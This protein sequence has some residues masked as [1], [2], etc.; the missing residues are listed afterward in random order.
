MTRSQGLVSGRQVGQLIREH[1]IAAGWTQ[2][3]LAD[4]AGL[5]IGFLRDLEQGRTLWPRWGSVEALAGALGLGPGQRAGLISSTESAA[6]G[7]WPA[8]NGPIL[9]GGPAGSVQV[10]IL[11][12]LALTRA[13]RPVSLGPVRQRAVLAMLALE[14]NRRVRISDLIEVLWPGRQPPTAVT[15]VQGYISGLRRLLEP[16]PKPRCPGEVVARTGDGYQLRTEEA[17]QVDLEEFSRLAQAG[18]DAMDHGQPGRACELFEGAL[19]LCRGR[20][21]DDIG[22]L[23]EHPAVVEVNIRRSD[24][25]LRYGEA[26]AMIGADDKALPHLQILCASQR[27]NEVAFA[28]LITALAATGQRAQATVVFEELRLRLDSELGLLPSDHV[29]DAYSRIIT[30]KFSH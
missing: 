11:G 6:G 28:R 19:S 7:R 16:E 30:S 14:A 25:V 17:C 3:Q 15:M 2:R 8:G 22:L 23:L 18:R 20:T 9:P 21:L 27:L 26:A 29:I 13:G 4:R 12:P 5:S 1:R 24:A 10:G